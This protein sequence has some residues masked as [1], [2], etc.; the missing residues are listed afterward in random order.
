MRVSVKTPNHGS[1]ENID[2]LEDQKVLVGR[3]PDPSDACENSTREVRTVRIS[4]PNVSANHVLLER[5]GDRVRVVDLDSRNGTW[6]RLTPRTEIWLSG[7]DISLSLGFPSASGAHQEGPEAAHWTGAA[8]YESA[9]VRAIDAWLRKRDVPAQL[10]T[11]PAHDGEHFEGFDR[12]PL[13]IGTDLVIEPSHTVQEDWFDTISRVERYVA[14]QN[15][16][17]CAEQ[18]LRE[19]GLIVASPAMR[20]AV[21][22]V[23]SAAARGA[24]SLLLLGPSGAGKEG[25]ARCFHNNARRAG[26]FTP[27]NCATLSR[28][29]ARSDLFGATKGSFTGSVRPIVGAVEQANEG[30]LFLDEVGELPIEVQPTLLRFLDRGEYEPLGTSTSR[31]ADVRLVCATNR[32]LRAASLSGAFRLDLWFRLSAHVVEIPPL[33][34]RTEDLVAYLEL[35]RLSNGKPLLRALT[36]EAL[37]TLKTHSW[38]GNFRELVNFCERV[39]PL[40]EQGDIGVRRC[41]RVLAEGALSPIRAS[42]AP[43]PAPLQ[44]GPDWS[45]MTERAS[46]AFAEDHEGRVPTTWDDVKDFIEGYLKPLMFARL[47]GTDGAS[48]RDQ[49]DLRAIAERIDA[50]RG[51]AAKQ[52]DRFLSRFAR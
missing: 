32:D 43:A 7:E 3:A 9:V 37:Q 26:R 19:Q 4:S 38:E 40:A 17:F 42:Q 39:L 18:E 35:R 10:R 24:K 29:F 45:A 50:D 47:S 25:L 20:E 13:A 8:D 52:L 41:E 44:E 46:A 49:L 48:S 15:A 33:R 22:R 34:S 16:V 2:L 5:T 28:E 11:H 21:A 51:T 12:I 36:A 6:A 14:L 23:V 31:R 30:T 1:P 27:I